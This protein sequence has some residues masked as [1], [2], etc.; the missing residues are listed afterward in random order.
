MYV[1]H[2]DFYMLIQIHGHTNRL[3]LFDIE[4]GKF[5]HGAQRRNQIDY[6]SNEKTRNFVVPGLPNFSIFSG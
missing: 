2:N 6:K 1:C 5:C 3:P 4:I